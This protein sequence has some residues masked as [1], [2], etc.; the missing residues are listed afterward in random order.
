MIAVKAKDLLLAPSWASECESLVV[1]V[2]PEISAV[3]A[4]HFLRMATSE[5]LEEFQGESLALFESFW[6][7]LP[8]RGHYLCIL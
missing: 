4:L 7:Y 3:F 6:A 8:L 1:E 5:N 2:L